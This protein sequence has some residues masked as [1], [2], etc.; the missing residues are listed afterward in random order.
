VA[1]LKEEA[2]RRTRGGCEM[3]EGG[4][5]EAVNDRLSSLAAKLV[6]P[7]QH[8]SSFLHL[9]CLLNNTE[10]RIST[11]SHNSTASRMKAQQTHSRPVRMDKKGQKQMK[12]QEKEQRAQERQLKELERAR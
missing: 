4:E 6:Q 2:E 3:G 10:A 1:R 5:G 12:A 11:L 8:K 9:Q 7:P